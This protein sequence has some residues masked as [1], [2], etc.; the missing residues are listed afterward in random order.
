V[1]V[2]FVEEPDLVDMLSDAGVDVTWTPAIGPAITRKGLYHRQT[3]ELMPGIGGGEMDEVPNVLVE[4]AYFRGITEGD[5]LTVDTPDGT[6]WVVRQ[7]Q[8][9][10]RALLRLFLA[11]AP[12]VS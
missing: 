12:V 6:D 5:A 11:V 4:I 10:H 8:V 1:P 9:P 7:I 2:P 3:E